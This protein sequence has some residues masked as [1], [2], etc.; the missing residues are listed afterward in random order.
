MGMHVLWLLA[1]LA[2]AQ[3]STHV[4]AT[5]SSRTVQV[6]ETV[7]LEVRVETD[8]PAPN[9]ISLPPLPP[10]L[11]VIGTRNYSQLQ[12]SLPG[13]RS[14]VVR[15]E[16]VLRALTPGRTR[17]PPI[18]VAVDGGR[19][20]TPPLSLSIVGAAAP[21]PGPSRAQSGGSGGSGGAPT[22]PPEGEVLFRTW[23]SRD[24]VYV[25]EQV[26]LHSEALFSEEVR[27]WLR[28]APEYEPPPTSGFW[29]HE[30]P[31][32]R[33][34]DSRVVDGRRYRVQT[35]RRAYFPLSAGRYTLPPA[36][37]SYDVRRGFLAAPESHR[38]AS[39]SLPLVVLRP[40][41]RGRPATFTGAVGRFRLRGRIEPAQVPAGEAAVL[42]LEV[43]GEGNIKALPA[44]ALPALAG[45]Q[46]YPP[47]EESEVDAVGGRVR[48]MKRFTW[49]LIPGKPGRIELPALEYAYFDPDRRAYAVARAAP[50]ALDVRPGARR[51]ASSASDE[52][53]AA[54]R[55]IES[56]P[57]GAPFDW[58]RS[59]GFAAV[60]LLPLLALLGILVTRRR[61]ERRGPP[62]RSALR[63]RRRRLLAALRP[64]A[65]RADPSFFARLAASVRDWLAERLG[66]AAL[67]TVAPDTMPRI[68]ED[69]GVAQATAHALVTLIAR[70]ERAPYEPDAPGPTECRACLEAAQRLLAALDRQAPRTRR[71]TR[72]GTTSLVL[73]VLSLVSATCGPPAPRAVED[74][75][76]VFEAGV[77]A[78]GRGEYAKAAG[79]FG[80]YVALRPRDPHGW[81]DL[82]N[83]YHRADMSGH[84]TWAWLR[85]AQLDPRN[86]D[87]RHNLTLAAVEP[88]LLRRATPAI[89][90]STDELLLLASIAWLSGA[91]A[92][93]AWTVRRR[94]R[95]A[96]AGGG[97]VLIALALVGGWAAP[98]FR[99]ATGVV[100]EPRTPLVAAPTLRAEAIGRLHAG[101]AVYVLE[102]DEAWLRVTTPA[103]THGWIESERV[104][105]L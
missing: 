23:L 5:L 67:R 21:G 64:L 17:I 13:G 50:L 49:V 87:I 1:A 48:G 38:L 32:R 93:G 9:S 92:L 66:A 70:V 24:T 98:R 6:G 74:A 86:A 71:K 88:D 27:L 2:P 82:G 22:R 30:L 63:R 14:R 61:A 43:E 20:R 16:V 57:A 4:D 7:V 19:Y 76:A 84:A 94:R 18:D 102:T 99:A 8:G 35:F 55:P 25:G 104:G 11:E 101:G 45:V 96:M 83:A 56:R 78:Y 58:V 97:A 41:A 77:A 46:V 95:I 91:I 15:R 26:T 39:D 52:A 12:F 90:L 44:P 62:S 75:R 33:G 65:D 89:P 10:A 85:A 37:L 73:A 51:V 68:L 36:R 54:L 53:R 31:N 28:R 60:Q 40:P 81:Y 100:L 29:V 105:L 80:D 72:P 3:D 103:G 42:T 59:R 47:T 34:L 69:R 79:A